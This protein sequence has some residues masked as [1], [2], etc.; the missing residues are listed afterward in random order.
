M[1]ALEPLALGVHDLD[2]LSVELAASPGREKLEGGGFS[3]N[4]VFFTVC[5]SRGATDGTH[6]LHEWISRMLCC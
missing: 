4:Q 3:S 5:V 6:E 1:G 2:V